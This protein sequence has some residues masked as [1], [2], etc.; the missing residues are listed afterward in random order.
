MNKSEQTQLETQD[1]FMIGSFSFLP[2]V[3][4]DSREKIINALND[5]SQFDENPNPI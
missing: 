4:K 1:V 2:F 3:K 5:V